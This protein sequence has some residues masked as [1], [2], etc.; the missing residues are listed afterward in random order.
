MFLESLIIT[1]TIAVRAYPVAERVDETSPLNGLSKHYSK[2]IILTL[3]NILS[4]F[5]K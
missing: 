4:E 1:N 2:K 3:V 5:D